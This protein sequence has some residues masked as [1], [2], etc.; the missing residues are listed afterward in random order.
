MPEPANTTVRNY[1]VAGKIEEAIGVLNNNLKD[2]DDL[3]TLIILSAQYK[4]LK[5]NKLMGLYSHDEETRERNKIIMRV[6]EMANRLPAEGRT[7]RDALGIPGNNIPND[8]NGPQPINPK[9]DFKGA[10]ISSELESSNS[11]IIKILFLGV[12]PTTNSS[13]S[14]LRIDQEARDIEEG[15]RRSKYR[16]RFDFVSRW[17]VRVDELHRCLMDESP[18]ILH[19]SGHGT[20]SK[21][22][23]FENN[24]GEAT[25]IQ[26][27]PLAELFEIL[28]DGLQC[29]LLNACYSEVQAK[30]IVLNIPYVIGM[31]EAIPDET[32]IR[33]ATA[34]Y[35]ALGAGKP[36]ELAF[37]IGK[38]AI[39]MSS[40][41]GEQLPQLYKKQA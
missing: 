29:V 24:A 5:R 18:T 41:D 22:L 34:F 25:A 27:G 32:S 30:A 38:N 20:G 33:F 12:N 15:L 6:L 28:S 8:P 21:G 11:N 14:K 35:D 16:D 31:S 13:T 40:L 3:Q 1:V 2:D 36:I 39:S 9:K 7:T 17:A 4:E 37:R 23:V 26:T 10:L 19:F